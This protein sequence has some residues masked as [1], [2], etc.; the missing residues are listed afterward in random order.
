MGTILNA[1]TEEKDRLGRT[2][3]IED[4]VGK[5]IRQLFLQTYGILTACGRR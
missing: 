2:K 3:T 5:K 1:E 4:K